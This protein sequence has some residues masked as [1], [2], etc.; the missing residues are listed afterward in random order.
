MESNKKE[1]Y[2]S[3]G[4]LD[5]IY[6][7]IYDEEEYDEEEYDEEE[8]DEEEYD[9]EEYDEE[10]YDEEEYNEEEYDNYIPIFSCF[11]NKYNDK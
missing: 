2:E 5:R 9:E 3:T 10:E 6:N 1:M 7:I 11:F 4:L 8:Y